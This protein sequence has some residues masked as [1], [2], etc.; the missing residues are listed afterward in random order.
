M[1]LF[2]QLALAIPSYK[3]MIPIHTFQLAIQERILLHY[4]CIHKSGIFSSTLFPVV[5]IIPNL[6][7]TTIKQ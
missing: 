3:P 6:C 2:G 7:G 5:Y 1:A 4:L